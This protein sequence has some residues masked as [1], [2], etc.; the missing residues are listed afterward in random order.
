MVKKGCFL[1]IPGYTGIAGDVYFNRCK[2][3]KPVHDKISIAL[4]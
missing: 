4:A 3:K 2:D 1:L